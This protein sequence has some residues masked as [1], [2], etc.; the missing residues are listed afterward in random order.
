MVTYHRRSFLTSDLA[1]DCLKDAMNETAQKHPFTTDAICL[2]PDHLHCIWTLPE[3]DSDFSIRWASI[4]ARF[5]RRYLD[6][7]GTEGKQSE[8][9]DRKREKGVWQRRFWEHAIR[10]D[11]D[12]RRHVD[13]IHF[14]PVKHGL[15]ASPAEWSWSSFH[16]YAAEGAYGPEWGS[17]EPVGCEKIFERAE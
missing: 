8:S 3:D 10:G 5:T 4:K 9:R 17:T 7:G 13:Y 1:R 6:E 16:R 15:A 14:N 12:F 11:D 2:L